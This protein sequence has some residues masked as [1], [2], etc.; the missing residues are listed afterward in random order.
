[1]IGKV[2]G[3]V[4]RYY[5]DHLRTGI[6][7]GEFKV[8]G[9]TIHSTITGRIVG[10]LQETAAI[11]KMIGSVLSSPI[12]V[13]LDAA[14]LG[15]DVV[16]HVTSFVQNEQIK[17]AVSALRGL[18]VAGL[19]LGAAGIGISLVGF[20]V[21]SQQIRRVEKRVEALGDKLDAI[22][23]SVEQ[24]R[25]DRIAEDMDDLRTAVQRMDEGWQLSAPEAQWRDVAGEM[26]KLQ[27]RF[28][29]QV[30]ELLTRDDVVGAEPFLDAVALASTIRVSARLA[31]GD[32]AVA[33]EAAE[34]GMSMLR[35]YGQRFRLADIALAKMR[36]TQ[37]PAATPQWNETLKHS[38][39]DV[40]PMVGAMR[41]REA[42]AASTVL[43]LNELSEWQIGGRDW[44]EAARSETD[45][46]FVFLPGIGAR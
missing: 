36:Q 21:M 3:D 26:H 31:A 1:M 8:Y 35:G 30:D 15:V 25:R 38:V 32:E 33:R 5:P 6:L 13:P 19:A 41:A 37:V 18:Q 40:R 46:P 9:S 29:R 11:G 10:H 27:T 34:K 24:L 28:S 12:S 16:G 22:A 23:V 44:M 20:A 4:V 45:A 17:A 7:R 43:T 42:A 14:K 2:L 39:E